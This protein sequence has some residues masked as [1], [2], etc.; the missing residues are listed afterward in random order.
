MRLKSGEE[1]IIVQQNEFYLITKQICK[2]TDAPTELE[3][4][5]DS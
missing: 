4:K 2:I 1:L 5:A 3:K